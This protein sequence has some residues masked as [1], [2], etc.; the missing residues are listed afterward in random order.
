MQISIANHCTEP[1]DPNR[2][3]RGKTEGAEWECNPIGRTM[4]NNETT[5]SSREYINQRVYME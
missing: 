3:A 5:Q 4:S 2:R 1:R